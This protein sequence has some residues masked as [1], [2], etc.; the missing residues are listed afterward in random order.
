MTTYSIAVDPDSSLSL[1][2]RELLICRKY[3]RPDQA[4][5]FSSTVDL[6]RRARLAHF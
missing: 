3:G 5:A 2:A 6:L 1:D 4:A